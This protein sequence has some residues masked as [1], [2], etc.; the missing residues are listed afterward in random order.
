MPAS[1]NVPP[2]F[3]QFPLTVNV[4]LL[5]RVASGCMVMLLHSAASPGPITGYGVDSPPGI[6]TSVV[7]KGI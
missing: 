1:V 2:L 6:M 7:A 4:L 5:V 3:T